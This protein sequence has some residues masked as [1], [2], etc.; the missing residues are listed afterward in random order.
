MKLHFESNLPYQA[1]AIESVCDLFK[2]QESCQSVFT[3]TMRASSADADDGAVSSLPGL[4]ESSQGGIGNKLIISDDE[5]L[6]NLRTVQERH[7]LAPSKGLTGDFTIEME[8]GTGKTYV[9]LRTVFELNKRYGFTKFAVVVPSVAIKEGVNKTLQITREHFEGLYPNAKGYE[10]FQY[11]SQKLGTVRNFATSPNIQ[12]M[13]ITIQSLVRK[14]YAVVYKDSEKTGGQRPID[15][16]RET[17]PIL[18]V[19]EPQSVDGGSQ[20]K[21]RQALAEL[22]PLCTLRYSATHMD[23]HNMVYKLDAVDAYEQKL[24][25]QIEVAAATVQGGH[26]KPYVKLVSITSK[27]GLVSAK[28]LLDVENLAGVHRQE[29]TVQDG[30]DLQLTTGRTLYADVRVGE[31]R[32][33]AA[34]V[35]KDEAFLELKVPGEEIYLRVGQAYGDVDEGAVQREMMKRTIREHLN[36]EKRLRPL[37][38][39]VLSLFFVDSVAKYRQYDEAGN[40]IKGEY[41]LMFE[42]EYRRLARHP[43]Y[44]S[45]FAEVDLTAAADAVHNGYFSIDKKKISGQ[46]VEMFKDSSGETKADDDTYNLIMRDKERL[47]SFDSPLKFIFS[48]SALKEGWDNPNVFQIC[49]F[50]SRETERWRRQT[51]GRGLR[52]CVNQAGERLRGFEIN[53]LTVIAGESYADFADKLQKDYEVDGIAFGTVESHQF[54]AILGFEG[55]LLLSEHLKDNGY[56]NSKG[57]VQEKLQTALKDKTLVLPE[58]FEPERAAIEAALQKLSSKLVVNDADDRTTIAIRKSVYLSP[59]FKALWDRIKHKTT[60]RVQ[61][62]NDKL[63]ESCIKA[64]QDA[65]QVAK[66]RL[67][68]RTAGVAMG[69]Q[70]IEVSERKQG[71]ADV[72]NLTESDVALPDVLTELQDRTQLTR[73]SIT[74]ILIESR[75]L[76]D[77]KRNPQQF[78][79]IV[80]K[81]VKMCKQLALVEGIRYQRLGDQDYYAQELLETNELTGYLRNLVRDTQRSVYEH[82][83]FDSGTERQFAEDLEKNEAVKVYAKL[84]G[85][86]KV[87]TPLE[88]YNPDWAVLIERDGREQLFFVAETKSSLFGEDLRSKER[89]KMAC[90]QAHFAALGRGIDNPAMYQKVKLVDDLLALEMPA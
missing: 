77:F 6:D 70:G 79:D 58:Q 12:I 2:G 29:V 13:V 44:A 89:G 53:T 85:W 48:H 19:D 3:V 51:I 21:G 24:V 22:N 36:K 34:R 88:A 41:A 38:V 76:N 57:K 50:S 84:P 14:D 65:P 86:F 9:Y 52:L 18:I 63:I 17:R 49:N 43:D 82:V 80:A 8:T 1:A 26:N 56:T 11:D 15:L 37:G 71:G 47:L 68:W 10:F 35:D 31:I 87:P 74:K 78:I 32:A 67:Q 81:A 54:A 28:V 55:S 62:D 23:K 75:R 16:I 45:L 42:E 83:V 30:D 25:K 4:E 39:K 59:E 73:Q 66:T 61:F 40:A 20:G 5:L 60:Y 46:S 33:A 90:A 7:S 69:R 72:V 64:V 27:R